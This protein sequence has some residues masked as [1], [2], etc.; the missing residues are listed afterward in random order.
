MN[1]K[2]KHKNGILYHIGTVEKPY[3]VRDGEIVSHR[4]V[5]DVKFRNMLFVC[6][7]CGKYFYMSRMYRLPKWFKKLYNK[8]KE[9]S[10]GT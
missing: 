10:R 6:T 9:Y 4:D 1:K 3:Y 5:S 2:C 8:L 7:D